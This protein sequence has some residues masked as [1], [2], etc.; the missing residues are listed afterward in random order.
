MH[1]LNVLIICHIAIEWETG[2]VAVSKEQSGGH[3]PLILLMSTCK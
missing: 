2:E 3:W 1:I